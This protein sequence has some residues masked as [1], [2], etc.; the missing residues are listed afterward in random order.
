MIPTRTWFAVGL[1]AGLA[2]SAV[3]VFADAY[4]IILRGKVTMQDG[5]PPA[6]SVGIERICTDMAGSAPGPITNKK[7]EFVWRMDVDPF[8]PRTCYVRAALDGFEST[9]VDISA[10][11]GVEKNVE[12]ETIVLREKIA[13]PFALVSSGF[14]IPG[15]S[16]DAWN[17]GIKAI[18]VGNTPEA[19][20]QLKKAVEATPKFAQGWQMLGILQDNQGNGKEAREAFQMAMEADPKLFA[21]PVALAGECNKLKDWACSTK[22]IEDYLK[23]DN[24][25]SYPTA[26]LYQAA[27]KL[28]LKD[29]AGAEAAANEALKAKVARGEY[30]LA[31]IAAEKGD[32]AAAKEHLSKYMQIEPNSPDAATLK[33]YLQVLGQPEANAMAPAI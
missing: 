23:A 9:R 10:L 29:M 26:Y 33:A 30:A 17:A 3:P 22:A 32:T 15:K 18:E 31:R 13:N 8:K 2:C 25:H 20:N 21:A 19:I 11:N 5:A 14:P 16:K 12:L 7:G 27:A 24:K 28:G 6:K 1:A 4:P